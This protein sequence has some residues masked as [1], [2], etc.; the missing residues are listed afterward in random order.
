MGIDKEPVIAMVGYTV[1]TYP[2]TVGIH[3]N[4]NIQFVAILARLGTPAAE[5]VVTNPEW[6]TYIRDHEA[7]GGD[8]DELVL[9]V[10]EG[11]RVKGKRRAD[12]SPKRQT[13]GK[14]SMKK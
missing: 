7:S 2:S 10:I 11:R 14:R 12:R 3:L 4:Q 9:E 5:S 1:N 13:R 6:M 8:M